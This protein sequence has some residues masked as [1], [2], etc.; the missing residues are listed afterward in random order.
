MIR[1]MHLWE[2]SCI[3]LMMTLPRDTRA[4]VVA[5]LCLYDEELK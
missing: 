4:G 3:D 1:D 5:R 2:R